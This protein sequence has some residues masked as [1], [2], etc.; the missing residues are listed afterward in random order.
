[1]GLTKTIR[2][3][4][5]PWAKAVRFKNAIPRHALTFWTVNLNRLPIRERLKLVGVLQTL[6]NLNQL[7]ADHTLVVVCE[8]NRGEHK[9]YKYI[10]FNEIYNFPVVERGKNRIVWKC[11]MTDLKNYRDVILWRAYRG[12][13]M[14]RCGQ[15]REYIADLKGVSLVKNKKPTKEFFPWGKPFYK[16]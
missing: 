7:T 2:H 5:K 11:K 12:A 10:Q 3:T 16:G 13:A 8:S 6:Y 9:D 4:T 15:I 14:T 1:M